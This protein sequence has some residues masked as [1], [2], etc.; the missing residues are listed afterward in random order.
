MRAMVEGGEVIES[1]RDRILGRVGCRR[2]AATPRTSEVLVPAGTLLD[3]DLIEHARSRT[4]WTKSRCAPP[5]TCETRYGLC[6]K[7]LWP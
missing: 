4:A 7:L 1:L 2:R 3:E 6:A 5:L